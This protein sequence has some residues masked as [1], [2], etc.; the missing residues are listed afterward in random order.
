MTY[1]QG[2][3]HADIHLLA[4]PLLLN[5]LLRLLS[6]RLQTVDEQLRDTRNQFH[7]GSHGHTQEEHLLDVELGYSTNQ[8]TYDDTQHDGLTQHTELTLQ[9]LGIDVEL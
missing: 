3:R 2:W 4:C 9:S 5:H 7:H 1:H 6:N 8:G